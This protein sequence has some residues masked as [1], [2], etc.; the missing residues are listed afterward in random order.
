MSSPNWAPPW[1]LGGSEPVPGGRQVVSGT[2]ATPAA[3][4]TRLWT[5]TALAAAELLVREAVARLREHPAIWAWNLGNEPDRW[6]A[7][8]RCRCRSRWAERL[9]AL[10]RELDQNTTS[11]WA[12]TPTRSCATTGFALTGCSMP[13]TWPSC[14][15]I[16]STGTSAPR[17]S[18]RRRALRDGPDR[19]AL[20]QADAHGGVRRLHRTPASPRRPGSGRR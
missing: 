4:A 7:A 11:P 6:R 17:R 13:R 12:C 18:A 19:V 1:L 20:G 15:R 16:P 10:I 3:T 8:R 14:T 9:F 2:I 5:P